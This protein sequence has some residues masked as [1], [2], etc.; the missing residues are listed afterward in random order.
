[1]SGFVL[2]YCEHVHSHDCLEKKIVPLLLS[3]N[4]CLV[5]AGCFDFI[6]LALS[7][8][9]IVRMIRYGMMGRNLV[10]FQV[11]LLKS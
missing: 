9:A 10:L 3:T 1:M 6:I 7:E 8:Y 11:N 4:R 5:S 2:P